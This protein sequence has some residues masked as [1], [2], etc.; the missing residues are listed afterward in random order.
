MPNH[1]TLSPL[2][3]LHN[4]KSLFV[5]S[6]LAG[7]AC[8]FL[9]TAASSAATLDVVTGTD[10]VAS[11]G[12]CHLSEAI[13]NI[14]NGA[15]T[16][17][18]CIATENGYGIDDTI[19]LP[20]GTITLSADLPLIT[21]SITIQGQGMGETIIDGDG[22]WQVFRVDPDTVVDNLLIS[23]M[24]I[25][26]FRESAVNANPNTIDD[27]RF[28][29]VSNLEVDG[30]GA[31]A[32]NG[33]VNGIQMLSRGSGAHEFRGS[34]LY[35]HNLSGVA[36]GTVAGVL[37]GSANNTLQ[38]SIENTT[39]TELEN[40][41]TG[42]AQAIGLLA[43]PHASFAPGQ[44]DADIS[45]VTVHGIDGGSSSA[46]GIVV[47][48]MVAGGESVVNA[49]INN[50]TA[51]GLTGEFNP[52]F[53]LPPSAILSAALA[54][55][56]SDVANTNIVVTNMLFADN[57]V[58]GVNNN[59]QMTSLNGG[60]GGIGTVNQSIT[61]TGGNLSDDN[62]CS[63]YFTQPSD[64]NNVAAL[65]ASLS[66]LADNGGFVPTMALLETS[67][68]V[69]AGVAVSGLT[70]DARLASRPQGNAYDSGAYESPF[71]RTTTT[72]T[73]PPPPTDDG[74]GLAESGQTI[75]VALVAVPVLVALGWAARRSSAYKM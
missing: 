8:F 44:I 62:S 38:V 5:L 28:L 67:P 10:T 75:L 58:D 71:T 42:G 51:T 3:K 54:T 50:V 19:N 31:I 56:P 29:E 39:I 24:T 23:S 73:T 53:P 33:V 16:N 40:T 55:T 17:T 15:T 64:Q 27:L 37:L 74:E 65:A 7:V 48:N 9:S 14:N 21:R 35:I 57:R 69:D 63:S 26:G 43:G 30:T 49:T 72:P 36:S 60:F 12:D 59:C 70:T 52:S 46:N 20:T 66:P 68:A 32:D 4:L 11:D 41:G 61:S 47:L 45:N 2:S 34:N 22:A 25:T 1:L 13:E 6:L 18:D